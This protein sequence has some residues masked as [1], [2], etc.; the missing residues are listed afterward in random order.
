MAAVVGE[1]P[2]DGG[3]AEL[4]RQGCGLVVVEQGFHEL[5][6]RVE[7]TDRHASRV[8]K[9]EPDV[10]RRGRVAREESRRGAELDLVAGRAE[11]VARLPGGGIRARKEFLWGMDAVAATARD[12]Q[13]CQ[14]GENPQLNSLLSGDGRESPGAS[15]HLQFKNSE[16]VPRASTCVA[17][18]NPARRNPLEGL[19][20]GCGLGTKR[21]GTPLTNHATNR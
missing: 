21:Q 9:A 15:V 13:D 17:N 5:R 3:L 1:V 18:Q 14:K 16:R 10:V 4:A 20:F 11:L 2:D 12:G 19:G 6:V 8:G 7:D